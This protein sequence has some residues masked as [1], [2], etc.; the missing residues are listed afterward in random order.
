MKIPHK[1]ALTFSMAANKLYQLPPLLSLILLFLTPVQAQTNRINFEQFSLTEGLSFSTVNEITQD[2][3][4]FVWIATEDGLNR[5]DGT[6]FRI[7]RSTKGDSTTIGNN[8]VNAVYEDPFERLWVGTTGELSL[9]DR[10]LDIFHTMK[11]TANV[12]ISGIAG[13][14]E[15]KLWIIGNAA[16]GKDIFSYDLESNKISPVPLNAIQGLKA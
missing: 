11:G 6:T 13:V 9:Y 5:Y 12:S 8:G 7:Y 15:S 14:S 1:K 10:D 2:H 16:S 3:R 4:G